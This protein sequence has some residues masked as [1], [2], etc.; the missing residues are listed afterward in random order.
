[1]RFDSAIQNCEWREDE[2]KWHVKIH[3]AKS[4][5]TF[6]DKC[7]ILIGANGLLNSWKW[8]T[9]VE[10]L[11]SFNGRL[12]HTARW[13]DDYTSEQW[14]NERVAVLGSG[15]SAIQVVPTMQSDVKHMDAFIRT[16]I[17]FAEIA[18]HGGENT[19]CKYARLS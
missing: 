11:S 6:E 1:M 9:E 16:P 17:W 15:A 5:T 2:G 4:G 7:D 14:R 18:G 8:P 19:D 12:I 3:D 13:P 10:G